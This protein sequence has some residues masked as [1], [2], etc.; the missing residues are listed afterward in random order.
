MTQQETVAWT[1]PDGKEVAEYTIQATWDD[2]DVDRP[3]WHTDAYEM[4]MLFGI[5]EFDPD[6][7]DYPPVVDALIHELRADMTNTAKGEDW[8]A[9]GGRGS[10]K[11]TMMLSW[12][13]HVLDQNGPRLGERVVWSANPSRSE[14]LPYR[15]WATVWLPANVEFEATWGPPELA[16][17]GDLADEVRTVRRYEDP[18]DLLEQLDES[19]P[20]TFNV[21][22][23]DPSFTGCEELTTRTDRTPHTLPFTASWNTFGDETGTPLTHWWFAFIL[24]AVEPW[25]PHQWIT[26]VYDEL[27]DL[28]EAGAEDDEHRTEKKIKLFGSCMSDSRRAL[29]SPCVAGHKR[30]KLEAKVRREFERRIAMPDG[31]G[32]PTKSRASTHPLSWNKVPM[33]KEDL[34]DGR[35][36]GV[37]LCFTASDFQLFRWPDIK[38]KVP[39]EEL[40]VHVQMTEPETSEVDEETGPELEYDQSIFSRWRRGDEDRLYVKD[41]GDGYLDLHQGIEAEPLDS[42]NPRLSFAGVEEVGPELVCR[43]REEQTGDLVDVAK[44]PIRGVG[45]GDADHGESDEQARPAGNQGVA[46]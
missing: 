21:V 18:V 34:L 31:T 37:A 16:P 26:W 29:L 10:G 25:S 19:P 4:R 22:Y 9:L 14:W 23:P 43:M 42:P 39:D 7:H 12:S 24:A 38:A 41:P 30:A 35:G 20:G 15:R 28:A 5:P 33:E 27:K 17:D 44:I 36:P 13:T 11:S 40:T 1:P 2:P 3:E 6:Q 8:L 46:D 32:N 45:L